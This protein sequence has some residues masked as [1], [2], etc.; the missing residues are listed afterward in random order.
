MNGILTWQGRLHDPV[1]GSSRGAVIRSRIQHFEENEKC[2]RYF[3]RK[4][5]R[6]TTTINKLINEKGEEKCEEQQI[7]TEIYDYYKNLYRHQ[8]AQE[9]EMV[10]LLMKLTNKLTHTE[11]SRLDQEIT[12]NEITE[13][14]ISMKNN[15]TPGLDGL[16]KEFYTTFW[17]S[18]KAPLL[19]V[20]RE[21]LSEEKLP[22][23]MNQGMISLL[24]K[25]GEK[26]DLKNWRPLTLLGVD[27]KIIAKVLF[28]RLQTVITTIIGKEQTCGVKGRRM[29]DSLAL[30]R[31]AILGIDLE[32]AF[33]S[34]NH[35]FLERILDHLNFGETFKRWIRTLYNECSSVAVVNGTITLPLAIKA[36]VR[37]GC[38]LSPLLFIIAI[39]PLACA[40]RENKMIKG[41]TPP[42]NEGK[43]IKLTIYMDDLTLLLADNVS[44]SESLKIS[45]KFTKASGMKVN[46]QKSEILYINWREIRENWGLIEKKDTIKHNSIINL[47]KSIKYLGFGDLKVMLP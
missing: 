1:G 5:F 42:G 24:Y 6:S 3:F 4:L 34:V 20:Y 27:V 30:I 33:D 18:L 35:E 41:I 8:A 11:K 37:Q 38:P 22:N 14:L 46:K 26:T 17:E 32:K 13:A 44:I 21:A 47:I 2:T 23:S 25:K 9:D 40:I 45:E 10:E 43:D 36:G 29:T 39:E 16:P 12:I 28:F 19:Q 31:D 7:L 15:K